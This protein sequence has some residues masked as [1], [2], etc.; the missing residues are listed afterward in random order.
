MSKPLGIIVYKGPS[1]LDG[2]PIVAIATGIG[3]KTSNEKIGDMLPIWIL[4]S[5]IGPQLATKIG[6][7]FSICGNCF[8]K[9]ANSCYVNI[10][11]GPRWVYEAFHR[12]RYKN[13][14]YDT[15]Q[16][17]ENRYMRFG[18][19]GDPAAVPIE[20]WENLAKI[21]KG[22]TGYSHQWKKCNPELKKY[23]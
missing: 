3:I 4:R 8:Q 7:D 2:K 11:H 17:L 13:L 22:Y 15:V 16:Y 5:D 18:A 20:I 12:D 23:C 10:C 9:H 6:E 1:L 19:Y 14:D 21:A